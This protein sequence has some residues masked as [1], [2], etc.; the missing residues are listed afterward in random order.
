MSLLI[1][2]ATVITV[3]SQRRVIEDGAIF[4]EGDRIVDL[5]ATDILA[6]KY[7]AADTVVDARGKVVL[8]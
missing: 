3:D 2:N 1:R 5:G 4:V 8:P 7:A 6:E